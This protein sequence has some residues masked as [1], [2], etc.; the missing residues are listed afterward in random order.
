[1]R[2]CKE[3]LENGDVRERGGERPV[4]NAADQADPA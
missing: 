1:M 2:T 3:S 4:S